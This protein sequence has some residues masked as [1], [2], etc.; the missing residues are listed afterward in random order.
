MQT[1]I[2][3]DECMEMLL[4]CKNPRLSYKNAVKRITK[5]LIGT[6]HIEAKATID[7]KLVRMQTLLIVRTS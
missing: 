5:C 2:K 4:G 1:E 3:S 6:Q 7:A